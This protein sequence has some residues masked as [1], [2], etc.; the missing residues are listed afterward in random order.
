MIAVTVGEGDPP[1]LAARGLRGCD[2]IVGGAAECRVDEREAVIL[3]DQVGVHE[4][5][6]SQLNE[7]LVQCAAVHRFTSI[8]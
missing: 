7:I 3:A 6:P 1:D 5:I 8:G 2:Q 4:A